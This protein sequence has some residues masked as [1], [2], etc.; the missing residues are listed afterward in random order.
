MLINYNAIFSRF[1]SS[2]FRFKRKN[3]VDYTEKNSQK[4]ISYWFGDGYYK[5]DYIL[6]IKPKPVS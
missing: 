6:F 2:L 1:I 4:N 5:G 3:K